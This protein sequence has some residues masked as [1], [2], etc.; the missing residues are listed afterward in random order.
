MSYTFAVCNAT[1]PKV[2]EVAE[3]QAFR[4]QKEPEPNPAVFYQ[5]ID[6]LI[7]RYPCIS[8]PTRI[9]SDD[10]PWCSGPLRQKSYNRAT[11]LGLIFSRVDEVLPFVIETATAI[12]LTVVDWQTGKVHRP[13]ER[14]T[15]TA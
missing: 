2:Y 13:R 7:A 6:R 12:G 8:D 5:L 9:D 15:N 11:V 4:L 10:G 1:L 3:E 14:N